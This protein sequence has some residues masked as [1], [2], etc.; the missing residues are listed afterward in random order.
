MGTQ[1]CAQPVGVDLVEGGV[2]SRGVATDCGRWRKREVYESG[3]TLPVY[4]CSARTEDCSRQPTAC[5]EHRSRHRS[6]PDQTI[7]VGGARK[8]SF[9][10]ARLPHGVIVTP[11]IPTSQVIIS[12]DSSS[13]LCERATSRT[14][15]I[16]R[17][18]PA[19]SSAGTPSALTSG[20]VAGCS[21]YGVYPEPRSW[22]REKKP[23][24]K[25][26][27]CSGVQV[28]STGGVF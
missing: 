12:H 25:T 3:N 21:S 6:Q 22:N 4:L 28:F 27:M 16:R 13:P 15:R 24:K 1:Q 2:E 17:G 20:H 26:I 8:S 18:L 23:G 7:G 9:A 11:G 5:P 10:S 14:Q 19:S